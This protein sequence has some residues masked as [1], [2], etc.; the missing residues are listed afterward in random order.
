M[1]WEK[2]FIEFSRDFNFIFQ[3]TICSRSFTQPGSLNTHLRWVIHEFILFIKFNANCL[4]AFTLENDRLVA[5]NVRNA[6][7]K[8]RAWVCTW[9]STGRKSSNVTSAKSPTV[10]SPS[11]RNIRWSIRRTCKTQICFKSNQPVNLKCF[12]YTQKHLKTKLIYRD[13]IIVAKNNNFM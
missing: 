11:L 10:K 2:A 7:H 13:M 3:C 12:T 1:T 6:S 9:K 8:R 4:I 5:P